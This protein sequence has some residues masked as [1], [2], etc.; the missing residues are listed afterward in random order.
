MSAHVVTKEQIKHSL[1]AWYQSM[2]QQQVEKATRLKEEIES[3]INHMEEDQ[4]ISFYYSLLDFRYQV[5]A[6]RLSITSNSFDKIDSLSL[7]NDLLLT[8]YYHLFKGIHLMF[9]SNYKESEIHFEK[10]KELLKQ[11]SNPI[12]QAEFHQHFAVLYHHTYKMLSSIEYINKAKAIFLNQEGYEVKVASCE[13]IIGTACI[14]LKQFEQAEEHLNRAID[15]LQKAKEDKLI[16]I[17][18]H[19][20]GLLYATQN[21]STLAIRHLSEVTEKLPNHIKAIFLQAREHY[22]LGEINIAQKLIENGLNICSAVGNKE[23]MYHFNILKRLNERCSMDLVEKEI[24]EGLFYFEKQGLWD[25]VEEYGELL[26]VKFRKLNNHEKVSDYFNICYEAK[27]KL[28]SRG[29]LK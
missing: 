1:D 14:F 11:V 15:I 20:L 21:L 18:R 7:P 4:N 26:A 3:K 13:N 29:A 27:Q 9:I 5:L 17:V 25:Y 19:N 24:K 28:L 2:L 10:A 12:E 16:L 23:Y 6:D 22:K 8:H